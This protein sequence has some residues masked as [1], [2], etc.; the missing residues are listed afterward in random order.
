MVDQIVEQIGHLN[1]S[2]LVE[3]AEQLVWQH[4]G[5]SVVLSSHLDIQIQDKD[6]AAQEEMWM[7]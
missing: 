3:L 5:R 7:D 4:E 1:Y 6:R 2:Q